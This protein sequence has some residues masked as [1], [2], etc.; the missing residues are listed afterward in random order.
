MNEC[1][2]C[3]SKRIGYLR[4]DSDWGSGGD[5]SKVNEDCDYTQDD[6]DSFESNERPDV[7]CYICIVCGT[8]F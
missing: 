2:N 8:T 1:P 3:K 7:E 4:I 5:W 6:L